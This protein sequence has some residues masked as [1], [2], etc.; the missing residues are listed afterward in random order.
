MR[1]CFSAFFSDSGSTDICKK[2][3]FAKLA[4]DL[5]RARLR[6][7]KEIS[8]L[9]EGDAPGAWCS[10]KPKCEIAKQFGE[11]GL[12]LVINHDQSVIISFFTSLVLQMS[13]TITSPGS[14]S[15]DFVKIPIN[16][17]GQNRNWLD[18]K[19]LVFP[20]KFNQIRKSPLISA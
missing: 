3:C 5:S 6:K 13:L 14:E 18:L 15:S 7:Q 16:G 9:C 20:Q 1:S 19:V 8:D 4:L 12:R 2:F 17:W 11:F 10:M